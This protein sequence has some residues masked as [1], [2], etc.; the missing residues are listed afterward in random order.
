[1]VRVVYETGSFDDSA[2]VG[3]LSETFLRQ[4]LGGR[5]PAPYDLSDRGGDYLMNPEMRQHDSLRDAAVLVPVIKREDGLHVLMTRRTEHLPNHAG[6][7]AFPGGK[8]DESDTGIIDTALREMEEEVG[9][10]RG[11]IDVIGCCDPYETGTGFLV[12]PVVAMMSADYVAR[13]DPG[14]V[15]EAFEVPLAHLMNRYHHEYREFYFDGKSRYFF[16]M[17]WKK[18]FIWGATG[19][20]IA[21]LHRHLFPDV[22]PEDWA[23]RT[24]HTVV[25]EPA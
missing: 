23:A 10:D 20:M 1:M 12:T 3:Q 17:P 7:V 16:V 11:E 8:V 6:Q 14:E 25:N 18:H 19:G 22:W 24:T 21:S 15:A 13:P 9:V 5:E 2:L 4:R